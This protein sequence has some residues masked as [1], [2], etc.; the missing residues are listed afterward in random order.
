VISG[1]TI[2]EYFDDKSKYAELDDEIQNTMQ[3]LERYAKNHPVHILISMCDLLEIGD[4]N[5]EKENNRELEKI[6][7]C[8]VNDFKVFKDFIG[9]REKKSRVRLIPISSYGMGFAELRD[10]K[11]YKILDGKS[12]KPFQMEMPLACTF[13]DLFEQELIDAREKFRKAQKEP[14]PT[15]AGRFFFKYLIRDLLGFIAKKGIAG[16]RSVLPQFNDI[17][18]GYISF[19]IGNMERAEE[20]R[21]LQRE[22][23]I[24]AERMRLSQEQQKHLELVKDEITAKESVLASCERLIGEL[25]T[26]FPSSLLTLE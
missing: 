10:G 17:S 8:L 14:E 13:R 12:P 7:K 21:K 16:L 6:K 3:L 19:T 15:I 11:M 20:R 18:D 24:E 26:N 22:E 25:E 9:T 5:S 23:E 4:K 2:S 1:Q